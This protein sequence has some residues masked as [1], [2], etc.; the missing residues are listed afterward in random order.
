MLKGIVTDFLLVHD[1]GVGALLQAG[2][3]TGTPAAPAITCGKPMGALTVSRTIIRPTKYRLRICMTK[4]SV[5]TGDLT[6]PQVCFNP[7]K[8][9]SSPALLSAVTCTQIGN[10]G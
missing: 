10:S 7:G 6:N 4:Y 1:G 9:L 2:H 8:S 5:D 3:P